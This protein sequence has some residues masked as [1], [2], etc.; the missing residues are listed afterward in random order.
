M[1]LRKY[2]NR[3]TQKEF[4]AR[5]KRKLT[6]GHF[7]E[8]WR[9]NKEQNRQYE[10]VDEK[11]NG[12]I[13]DIVN[14]LDIIANTNKEIQNTWI[15]NNNWID[16]KWYTEEIKQITK[17]KDTAYRRAAR[18]NDRTDWEQYRKYRNLGVSV[19]RKKKERIL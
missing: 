18:T 1:L 5:D 14:T 7:E 11:A 15:I 2:N 3:D 6:A 13:D 17:Q 8:V 4:R 16:K 12:L 19:I 9:S 10:T